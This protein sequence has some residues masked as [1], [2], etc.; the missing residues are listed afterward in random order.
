MPRTTYDGQPIAEDPPF[1]VTVVVH[2]R[3]GGARELLMLHRAHHGPDFAG[4]WAWT[5]PAGSRW[6]GEAVDASAA[7]EL[8]EE[9]GLALTLIPTDLGTAEWRLYL[10]E[11]PADAEVRLDGEHDRY[12]WL[13]PEDAL[14][15]CAPALAAEPLRQAIAAIP[16][17]ARATGADELRNR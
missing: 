4:D 12:A 3:V 2:R 7:R 14:A 5:A 1:G 11:A 10:A 13:R 6:P 8:M 16:E 15:C 17:F 9:T